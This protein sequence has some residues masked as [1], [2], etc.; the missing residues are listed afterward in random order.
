[1]VIRLGY[2]IY[3]SVTQDDPFRLSNETL[4]A[5]T[6]MLH[7]SRQH[8]SGSYDAQTVSQKVENVKKTQTIS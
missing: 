8:R 1:M 5:Q 2:F 3:F 6:D 4:R 7:G